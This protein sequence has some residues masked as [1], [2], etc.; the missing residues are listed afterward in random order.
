MRILLALSCRSRPAFGT[1][2]E[3]QMLQGLK[4]FHVAR[5]A[6]SVVLISMLLYRLYQEA[7]S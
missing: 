2:A 7:R 1:P 6:D 5:R 4:G 3:R